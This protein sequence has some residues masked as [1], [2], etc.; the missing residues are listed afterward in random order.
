MR[1][2]DSESQ[3]LEKGDKNENEK[4]QPYNPGSGSKD[5]NLML[6]HKRS[7]MHPKFNLSRTSIVIFTLIGAIVFAFASFVVFEQWPAEKA[8]VT[9]VDTTPRP[10]DSSVLAAK[11]QLPGSF[12]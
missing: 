3:K 2:G 5:F 10:N 7:F 12:L 4:N 8:T 6:R 9:P 1:P 11:P